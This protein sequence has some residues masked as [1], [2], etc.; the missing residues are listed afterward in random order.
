MAQ[1]GAAAGSELQ[2]CLSS[3][4]IP[5][6]AIIIIIIIIMEQGISACDLMDGCTKSFQKGPQERVLFATDLLRRQRGR[7]YLTVYYTY[8]L[9]IYILPEGN[10]R[11]SRYTSHNLTYIYSFTFIFFW[12]LLLF[13]VEKRSVLCSL[14]FFFVV[15]FTKRTTYCWMYGFFSL[16]ILYQRVLTDANVPCYTDDWCLCRE[17]TRSQREMTEGDVQ[18][19]NVG[20]GWI[21][22]S[23]SLFI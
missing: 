19:G 10:E 22:F 2:W 21:Y 12:F 20:L 11:F 4:R 18:G 17:T 14:S 8:T 13:L 9:Y 1:S 15:I 5:V 7:E 16:H 6:E 3:T 23:P